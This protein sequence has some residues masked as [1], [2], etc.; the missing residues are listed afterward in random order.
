MITVNDLLLS[1]ARSAAEGDGDLPVSIIDL[2]GRE[3]F[4]S[5]VNTDVVLGFDPAVRI[6][7]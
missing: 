3:S 7:A 1:L 5:G 6:V 4:A 2:D